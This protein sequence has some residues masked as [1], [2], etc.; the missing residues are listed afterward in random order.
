MVSASL[1]IQATSG[2]ERSRKEPHVGGVPL[3]IC[4]DICIHEKP[5]TNHIQITSPTFMNA[6]HCFPLSQ[7]RRRSVRLTTVT[8][9][10]ECYFRRR[11][12]GS[13]RVTAGSGGGTARFRLRQHVAADGSI[14][15]I[16]HGGEFL[17]PAVTRRSCEL[18]RSFRSS[19]GRRG[20]AGRRRG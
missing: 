16:S 12:T 14:V 6:R 5:K 3:M 13:G 18:T 10:R 8:R 4:I 11:N 19:A 1:L 2:S 17:M 9:D 7:P 20:Y 15:P